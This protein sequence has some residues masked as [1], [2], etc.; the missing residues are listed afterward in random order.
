M[1][2]ALIAVLAI[3]V[4][5]SWKS[6]EE[7]VSTKLP[8]PPKPAEPVKVEPVVEAAPVAKSKPKRKYGGKVKKEKK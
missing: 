8:A 3:V 7:P 5:F 2:I 1:W 6:M 4:Y